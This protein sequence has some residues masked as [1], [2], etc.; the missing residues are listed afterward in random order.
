MS[1]CSL[2]WLDWI[3]IAIYL[4]GIFALGAFFARRQTSTSEF[5]TA[6]G[7]LPW[8]LVAFSVVAS[9]FSGISYIGQPARSF[10]YDSV[11]VTLSLSLLL[12]TPI[13]AYV[14]LPFYR[15]L[16]VTTAYEYLEKR[17]G[18]NIRL[19]ASIL[20]LGKR[21]L[22]MALVAL[23][24]SL[25]LSTFTGIRVEYCIL[26]IGLVATIYTSMG[27]ISAV[28]WTD[29]VQF[30]VL[31]LGQV[32]IIIYIATRIDGGLAEIWSVG[33]ENQK[34]WFSMDF[35]HTQ[36]TFWTLLIAGMGFYL[37]DL[38][39]DQITVQR[40]LTTKDQKSAQKALWFNALF[41][42]PGAIIITG[43]GVAL[44]V[45]YHKNPHLLT[46][47]PQDYDKVVPYFVVKE[48]PMGIAGL[49]IAAIFA[50]AMSSFD[51]GLNSIITGF[52]VDWYKR[53]INPGQADE[54]YLFMAKSLSYVVGI[55]VTILAILIYQT[56]I[57]SIID[58]SN[59]YLGFFGGALLG[60]FILGM[61]T[62]RAKAL[63]TILASILSVAVIFLIDNYNKADDKG[64][65][66]N[67]IH[68]YLY[69]VLSCAITVILGYIGSMFGPELSYEKVREFTIAKKKEKPTISATG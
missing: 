68:P 15:R 25:V 39:A 8:L 40:L 11:L 27:G 69:L 14:F 60:L 18:L 2:V 28:I 21:L 43:M 34:A 47:Q 52:T 16:N 32:L 46:L 26:T 20:F 38:G 51:S 50:A 64:V 22:W 10:R 1:E 63:P 66:Y 3:V 29:A 6:R 33:Y 58:T 31:V 53:L 17:F 36:L 23:A 35:N 57:K 12:I 49:V 67:I 44:W 41:K 42:I 61:F 62:R 56:G 54:K 65:T 30:I 19:F 5:F 45:F 9:L 7:R 24:P 59:K 48:L 4:L 13:A 55:A 37:S